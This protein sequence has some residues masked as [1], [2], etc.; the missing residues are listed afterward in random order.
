MNH[1]Y[2]TY[3][4]NLKGRRYDEELHGPTLSKGFADSTHPDPVKYALEAMQEI[5]HSYS[6]KLFSAIRGT[7]NLIT[8]KLKAQDILV[9]VRYHGAHNTG[10]HIDLYGDLEMLLILKKYT[11][12]S[13]DVGRLA[14][15][16]INILNEAKAYNLVDYSRKHKIRVQTRKPVTTIHLI[17]SIWLETSLYKKNHLEIN[18]GVSEYNFGEKKKKS[19]MPFLNMARF[20]RKD[21]VVGG[22]LKG[23]TRLIRSLM[24]DSGKKFNVSFEELVGILYNIDE[25]DLTAPPEFQLGLLRKVSE[26]FT[27]VIKSSEY[28]R[29]L[30]SPSRREYVFGQELRIRDLQP[31]K[32]EID[33]FIADLDES[34]GPKSKNIESPLEY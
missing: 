9:D 29:K 21:R 24:V 23:M 15:A 20:N 30:L 5:D 3:L 31:L 14:K 19:H 18:M 2:S 26:Q 22:G 8:Q 1:S 33:S 6:Y 28:S 25:K 13:A 34:L 12:A 10:T 27:R 7:Q 16:T 4:E 32:N 17:P 11:K